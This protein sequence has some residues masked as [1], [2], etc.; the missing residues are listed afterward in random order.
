M[1]NVKRPHLINVLIFL[2]F[3]L[4]CLREAD[5]PLFKTIPTLPVSALWRKWLVLPCYR[6][7][8]TNYRKAISDIFTVAL[9]VSFLISHNE[10]SFL[11]ADMVVI[12]QIAEL[13]SQW[14]AWATLQ[15]INAIANQTCHLNLP[16]A[17][18]RDS[19]KSLPSDTLASSNVQINTFHEAYAASSGHWFT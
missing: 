5:W 10:R 11:D 19:M 2:T 14:G 3:N 8:K 12:F 18:A 16:F 7:M 9:R 15:N 6:V 4:S 13:C 17:H 1:S